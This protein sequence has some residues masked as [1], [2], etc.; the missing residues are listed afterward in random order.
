MSVYRVTAHALNLRAEPAKSAVRLAVLPGGALVES[1]GPSSDPAWL[2]VAWNGLAGYAAGLHLAL[3]PGRA[4]A[5]AQPATTWPST[6]PP[7]PSVE[8]RDR[9]EDHLHPAVRAAVQKTLATLNANGV[10]FA[11]FEGYRTPE[12]QAWLHAQGRTRPGAVVTHAKPWTSYHQYG[13]ACDLVLFE[14]GAW[15]WNDKGSHG[16]WWDQMAAEAKAN[17]LETLSFERPHVQWAGVTDLA[18]G[19]GFPP[20][21]DVSWYENLSLCAARWRRDGRSPTAPPLTFAERPPLPEL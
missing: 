13:L 2:K 3:E 8:S 16:G 21:G 19:L 4:G 1:E 14:N 20:A 6:F 12:R 5:P 18:K 17:G 15:S 7:A 10:P 11:L 9:R